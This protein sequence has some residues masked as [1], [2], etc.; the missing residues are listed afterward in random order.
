MTV[1]RRSLNVLVAPFLASI[2]FIAQPALA[3]HIVNEGLPPNDPVLAMAEQ[4]APRNE[5]F[6]NSSRD[7]ELV[8]FKRIHDLNICAARPKPNAIGGTKR[9][10]PLKVNWGTDTAVV[11]PGN[12]LRLNAQ[13]VSVRSATP[14]PQ[15]IVLT[16]TIRVMS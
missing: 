11:M 12:C 10:Y 8:R 3:A 16:G 4:D 5:F 7:T 14:I 2:A 1:V 13:Q 9:G 6:L 15:N